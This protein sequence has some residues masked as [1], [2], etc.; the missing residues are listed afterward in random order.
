MHAVHKRPQFFPT[1]AMQFDMYFDMI[2][3]QIASHRQQRRKKHISIKWQMQ[4]Q[5]HTKFH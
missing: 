5:T 3:K 2:P 1:I 4:T